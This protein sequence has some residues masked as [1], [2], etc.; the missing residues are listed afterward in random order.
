MYAGVGALEESQEEH[1][2]G[3]LRFGFKDYPRRGVIKQIDSLRLAHH[4]PDKS[5]LISGPQI[6][7]FLPDGWTSCLKTRLLFEFA[8]FA[9]ASFARARSS[10]KRNLIVLTSSR[11]FKRPTYVRVFTAVPHELEH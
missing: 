11:F 7:H 4:Y 10:E 2:G 8:A 1:S 5:Q 9:S 3:G 6:D